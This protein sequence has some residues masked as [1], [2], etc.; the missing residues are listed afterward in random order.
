M[1]AANPLC[2]SCAKLD[3]L[4]FLPRGDAAVTR[5]A[6]EY[7]PLSAVVVQFSRRRKRYE[8]QGILIERDA[9]ARA[10]G[11]LG[12]ELPP[13]DVRLSGDGG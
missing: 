12:G 13:E 7:S 5:R 9:L 1:E 10:R 8:R 2:L 11:G 4:I 3:H 6:R